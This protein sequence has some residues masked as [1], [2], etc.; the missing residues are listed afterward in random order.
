MS[1]EDYS[2][3]EDEELVDQ[4]I[5]WTSEAVVEMRDITDALPEK[6]AVGSENA[7]RLYDL[8]HN[9]KGMGSSFNFELMTLIGTSFCEYY[10]KLEGDLSRRVAHAHVRGFEVVLG[11]KITGKGGDKGD[12]LLMRLRD[13]IVEEK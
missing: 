8:A 9:I 10:K 7:A 13:I 5:D 2:Y 11:N 4:F 12:A 6:V 1:E 3:A